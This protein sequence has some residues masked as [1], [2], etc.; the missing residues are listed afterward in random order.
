MGHR[1]SRDE[2]LAGA[3]AVA[4]A[5][6]LSRLTFGRVANRLT[7]HDRTVVYY[8]PTKDDLVRE[9]LAAIESQ[10]QRTLA[11]ALDAGAEGHVDLLRAA[12]PALVHPDAEPTVAL[13]LEAQ[14]LAAAEREPYST[15]APRL[16]DARIRWFC[17]HLVGSPEHRRAEAETAIAVLDGLLLL[18]VTAGP[19]VA[20]G[21]AR[22]LG[23]SE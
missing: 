17:D 16:L 10:L 8:F 7:V 2:I 21:V 5:D 3:L 4:S 9:V 15:V 14:G 13:L 19:E 12:W 23:I 11:W 22:R 6:G 20:D 1:H 18:R